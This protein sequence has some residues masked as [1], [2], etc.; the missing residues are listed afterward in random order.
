MTA[1]FCDKLAKCCVFKKMTTNLLFY[2]GIYLAVF[3]TSVT[4]LFCHKLATVVVT[5]N[6]AVSQHYENM[7]IF[8]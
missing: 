5:R 2:T 6:L 8:E 1:V 4:K 7:L 3:E